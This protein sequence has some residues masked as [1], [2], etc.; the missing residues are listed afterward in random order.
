M[1]DRHSHDRPLDEPLPGPLQDALNYDAERRTAAVPAPDR[2]ARRMVKPYSASADALFE[3]LMTSDQ[4]LFAHGERRLRALERRLNALEQSTRRLTAI[5]DAVRPLAIDSNNRITGLEDELYAAPF[6]DDPH[7]LTLRRPDGSVVL[8]Y[9]HGEP[10]MDPRDRYADFD[11][12]FRGSPDRVMGQL[13][14]YLEM[15][16]D[17]APVLDVGCG[18][19]EMLELLR[20][21]GIRARG[22]DADPGMV[23]RGADRGLDITL[24]DAT[25]YL[26]TEAAPDSLGAI[27][28]SQVIEHLPWQQLQQFLERAHRALRPGGLLI[29]ETVNPHCLRSLKAFWLDPTHQ[30]PLFPEA[31]LV[32]CRQAGFAQAWI[33]FTDA[34]DELAVA[35]RESDSYAVIATRRP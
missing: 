8:G 9:D 5:A 10:P 18:R 14:P 4:W 6:V 28:C 3:R 23:I 2:L 29:A 25:T 7:A 35:R 1:N 32:F 11:G 15:L 24:G 12:V 31:M 21:A 33:R 30:H 19:G 27:F 26:A 16:R 22:V 20:D 34:S 17:H 13:A